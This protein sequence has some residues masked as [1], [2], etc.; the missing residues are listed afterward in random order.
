MTT[1]ASL[2]APPIQIR[3]ATPEDAP[4]IARHRAGMFRDMGQ[5]T[6]EAYDALVVVAES[7]LRDA[8]ERRIRGLA[9][10]RAGG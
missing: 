2:T 6:P 8:G 3:P 7:R 1:A 5:V 10:P 9:G 4:V